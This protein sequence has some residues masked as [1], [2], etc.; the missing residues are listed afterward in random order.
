MHA[1]KFHPE[2]LDSVPPNSE[3]DEMAVLSAVFLEESIFDEMAVVL[4]ADEFYRADHQAIYNAFLELHQ[5]RQPINVLS[6]LTQLERDGVEMDRGQLGEIAHH[7]VFA[8]TWR[9]HAGVVREKARKRA[10]IHASQADLMD[11]YDPTIDS[12]ECQLRSDKRRIELSETTSSE[13]KTKSAAEVM[14]EFCESVDAGD[15]GTI[16]V[17]WG[18]PEIDQAITRMRNSEMIVIAARPSM[19]KSAF[20]LNVAEHNAEHGRKVLAFSLEMPAKDLA[21]RTVCGMAGVDSQYVFNN[22]LTEAERQAL[23]QATIDFG[24]LPL[25]ICDKPR[26]TVSDILREAMR[27]KR[28]HGLDLLIVDYLGLVAPDNPK[29]SRYEQT[30][31][32]SAGMKMIAREVNVPLIVLCQLNRAGDETAKPTLRE[33]RDSGAIEQDADRVGFIVRGKV[34]ADKEGKRRFVGIAQKDDPNGM[35]IF[36]K[37]RNGP[38]GNIRLNWNAQSVR[39]ESMADF[40]PTN[41]ETAFD[42]HDG[43]NQ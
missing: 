8:Q 40:R 28:K 12:D 41:R 23:S 3:P 2:I 19:G 31:A 1:T 9:Y 43:R 26:M 5:K 22:S 24:R 20:A 21:T 17:P 6:V 42:R 16:S 25:H 4:K 37:N 36:D 33:L 35:L 29:A 27:H 14:V 30:T 11:A 15:A 34:E 39:F 10:Y 38:L 13:I 32:I 18:F 7:A